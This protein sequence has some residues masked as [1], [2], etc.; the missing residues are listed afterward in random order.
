[1]SVSCHRNNTFQL[2]FEI[3]AHIPIASQI[4]ISLSTHREKKNLTDNIMKDR[5]QYMK[6]KT[7]R[8]IINECSHL[9]W[10][11]VILKGLCN[12]R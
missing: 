9:W 12:S 4:R 6:E 8:T 7:F 2:Q 10:K 1:M 3:I 5:R 11:S